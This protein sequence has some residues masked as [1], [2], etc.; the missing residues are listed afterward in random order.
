MRQIHLTRIVEGTTVRKIFSF[1]SFNEVEIKGIHWYRQDCTPKALVIVAHGMMETMERYDEMATYFLGR[2]IFFYGHD[3]RGHGKT[4]GN[5]DQLGDLGEN[6]WVKAREDVKRVIRL[7]RQDYPNVPLFLLG[8]SMGSFLTRDL[9][10]QL[11]ME[12]D[13]TVRKGK[14]YAPREEWLPTGVILSGTGH[15]SPIA[16]KLGKWIAGMEMKW[17]GPLHPSKRLYHLSFDRY[18]KHID[19]PST[20]FDWLSC[21]EEMV[22]K[23]MKDPYCGQVH[24]SRFYWEFFHHLHRILYKEEDIKGISLPMYLLSGEEDP[25]GDYGEAV[26]KTEAFYKE[27]GFHTTMKLYPGGRHE[28]LNEVN[29]GAVYDNILQWI[30]QCQMG[31]KA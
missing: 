17:K 24:T 6:G 9:V 18:N 5:L 26:V 2:E 15:P 13:G 30:G 8:H 12:T 11:L 25:V 16:L 7:A 23:Y 10:H 21:D 28:M 20:Y 4:A 31:P 22:G 27:K 14:R 3:Q 19:Q 1:Q 29:R